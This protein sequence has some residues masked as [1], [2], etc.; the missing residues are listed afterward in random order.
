MPSKWEVRDDAVLERQGTWSQT[1]SM[2]TLR[3]WRENL[4]P[5]NR[6]QLQET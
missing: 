5:L 3:L 1:S 4:F 2:D 6:E